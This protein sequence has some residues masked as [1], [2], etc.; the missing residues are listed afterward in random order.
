[1]N[2]SAITLSDKNFEQLSTNSRIEVSKIEPDLTFEKTTNDIK[3]NYLK[4]I[5]SSAMNISAISSFD[6]NFEQL[7]KKSI[8][9]VENFE[10]EPKLENTSNNIKTNH[11][12]SITSIDMNLSAITSNKPSLSSENLRSDLMPFIL[13]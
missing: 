5:A 8:I 12:K 9:V 3:Y 10:P 7:I 2:L 13:L 1:M 4:G 6:N 11:L